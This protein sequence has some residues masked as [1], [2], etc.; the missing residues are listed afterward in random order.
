MLLKSHKEV[1]EDKVHKYYQTVPGGKE[2]LHNAKLKIQE[3]IDEDMN[4]DA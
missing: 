3:L 4:D 1:M 2:M